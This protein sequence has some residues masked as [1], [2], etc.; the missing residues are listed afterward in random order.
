M[1]IW[2]SE[3]GGVYGVRELAPAFGLGT[4]PGE[5]SGA[6]PSAHAKASEVP[7]PIPALPG[8]RRLQRSKSCASRSSC[9]QS[10]RAA[11][12]CRTHENLIAP[13]LL[14]ILHFAFPVLG[15]P[16]GGGCICAQPVKPVTPS[17]TMF[18]T[19]TMPTTPWS[20]NC[21]AT[22]DELFC[23][24]SSQVPFHEQFTTKMGPFPSR[25]P[26]RSIKPNQGIYI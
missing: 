9:P 12:I 24:K 19:L 13:A 6:D 21:E 8:P 17:Q 16:C 26:T 15:R 22:T 4:I 7:C 18:S 10:N 25:F 1:L 20:R 23:K 3:E 11:P 2:H 5:Q 14:P